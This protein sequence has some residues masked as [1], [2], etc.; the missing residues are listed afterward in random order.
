MRK[1]QSPAELYGRLEKLRNQDPRKMSYSQYVIWYNE[2]KKL[3][4]HFSLPII[5]V[6]MFQAAYEDSRK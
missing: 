5:P 3:Q 1:E 2:A 6:D 4:A